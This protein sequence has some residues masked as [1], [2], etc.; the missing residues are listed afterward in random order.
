MSKPKAENLLTQE[1]YDEYH[2]PDH[3]PAPCQRGCPV[4]TDIPSYVGL[5]AQGRLKEAFEVISANNP[6][7]T[8]CGRVC[9]MPC[10]SR[11]RRGESD[12]A[13][14]IRN[15]KRF[16]SDQMEENAGLPPVPVSRGKTIGIVGGGPAGLT[17]A[18][19]L[20][21]AG[22]E[23]HIYE[24]AESLGGMAAFGIPVFRLPRKFIERDIN[25]MLTHCP[26][27][28][29][30][31]NCEL[32]S[33]IGLDELK[34]KHDAVLLAIGLWQD[35][36][37]GVPGE[38]PGLRGLYG[39]DFLTDI[40]KGKPVS[41]EGNVVVIGGGN[42]AIDVART[43]LRAGAG[44]VELFCLEKREEM[45]AWDH[46]LK[47]ALAEGVII[48]NA[49]GP[50]SI[51]HEN[52][53][54]TGIE[55]MRCTSAFDA[56]GRFNP[57]L[58]PKNTH[59]VEAKAVILATGLAAVNPELEDGGILERGRLKADF[60]T[61]RT[62]D[63]QVFAAGDG[64]FGPSAIVFAV[65]HGHR[66]AHYIR[67]F[68]EGNQAPAPYRVLYSTC[69]VPLI[70]DPN[71]EKLAREEQK[72]DGE[73]SSLTL[74]CEL[75]YDPATARR[76]AARCL[77]CDTETGTS[78]YSRRTR[79]HIH[80]MAR[81]EPGDLPKLR[82]VLHARLKQ[83]DNPFPKERPA[84]FD[85]V[86]FLP[87]ALTRLVI[88]PY[89]EHCSTATQIG[90]SMMLR[91]PYIFTGFDE[92]PGEVREALALALKATGCGYLGFRSPEDGM[93]STNGGGR[94][95]WLQL[96]I[97]GRD[98]PRKDADGLVYLMGREFRPVSP[99]RARQD[100][101][102]GLS[103]VPA[104]L[105]EAISYALDNGFDLLVLDGTPGIE[106]PWAELGGAP[107]LTVMRDALSTLQKLNREEEIDLLYFG[108]LR[109]GTDV[110]K[111]LAVNC[112]AAVLGVAMGIAMGGSIE[113]DQLAFT[114]G[115]SVEERRHAAENW[116]K[117]TA[118]ETAIIA[119]CTGKT[120]VHN[121]EPED[122][123]TITLATADAMNIPLASGR[124]PRDYF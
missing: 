27:I 105:P 48:H 30:H 29:V 60:E 98:E 11:C 16:V 63:P 8:I 67:A 86:V 17:A 77:R 114:N 74:E 88:D 1:H 4:G 38:E 13:V 113:D 61:M 26:G 12:G 116:I 22:Y 85:D 95:P 49:W 32:G 28:K 96:V 100:Q 40:N 66:A 118:Q 58:D 115:L 14:T 34:A 81:T 20:A 54:L 102:I 76:Q 119:R 90:D 65:H 108:G 64:A 43:A 19:D 87:A 75:T 15:L 124:P 121:L 52:G 110:A 68:L 46:E 24:K 36:H 111:I 71:W 2:E 31:L 39:I 72:A 83:R 91:Q 53:R 101:L 7:S 78:D 3:I 80:M 97:P 51:L 57:T 56:E 99:L 62:S 44:Q 84:Q 23:V 73:A 33:R 21:E 70:Q 18:H 45:P 107:D 42:V 79:E 59:T 5:I 93:N 123:R 82:E 41:L 104:V 103:V 25:R 69:S 122:M 89:R 35:R 94:V 6:F 92:A 112:K 10:E 9:A 50:K 109:S 120:N 37:L 117:G 47:E 55:F 106:L